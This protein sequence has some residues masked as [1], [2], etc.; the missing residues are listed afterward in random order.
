[1]QLI[2]QTKPSS[3]LFIIIFAILGT[4][5][6]AQDCDYR[7]PLDGKTILSGSYGEPRTKH[8]HA[9]IDY[10]Q[11]RGIPYDTIRA[12]ADGYISRINV[13][14]DGYGNALYIDHPCGQTSVYAH[15]YHF[16]PAI[17]S[18]IEEVQYR[19][20][21]NAIIHYPEAGRLGVSK[22]D[23]IGIMGSTGR[24]SGP[25][26]HF[27]IRDTKTEVSINPA[28]YNFKPK[29]NIPPV[30][31]GIILYNLSPDGQE[32]S[33]T[34]H[35][36]VKTVQGYVTQ[37]A[38]ITTGA[39][40]VGVG[41]HTYDT[42]NG[43]SNHNGIYSLNLMVDQEGQYRF[44][45]DS[46]SFETSQF[47]H[48]HMDY[49]A[50]K[51]K[52]Y[53]TKCFKNPG[54]PLSIYETRGEAGYL[55][56]YEYRAR[57]VQVT[58]GDIEG[59]IAAVSFQLMRSDAVPIASHSM[60]RRRAVRLDHMDSLMIDGHHT[61]LMLPDGLV[62]APFF[63][64]LD[65]DDQ[66]EVDLR[67]EEEIPMFRYIKVSKSLKPAHPRDQYCFT[68]VND[69]GKTTR[70]ATKWENDSTLVSFLPSFE[71]YQLE[72]DTVPPTIQIL[73]MPGMGKRL[74]FRLS[75]NYEPAYRQDDLR[76]EVLLDGKWILCQHDIKSH[77]IWFDMTS[78][79]QKMHDVIISA[80][81]GSN[82]KVRVER[83]FR[84]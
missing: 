1:L 74:K 63:L 32:I 48:S 8:F 5:V 27:E 12:V 9:G 80:K 49:E 76:Y 70:Y 41:I 67:Q 31:R 73:S 55:S 56:L 39:M 21:K 2:S 58:V 68:S 47:I 54:N 11:Q 60:S 84:Y 71:K 52:K 64:D 18:Y 81:D 14:P 40:T 24:S 44:K 57:D 83:S 3:L 25:H 19:A 6:S 53:F 35:K 38:I 51:N 13:R 30:I 50:K 15:L 22:G 43:A 17:K 10:K 61:D 42:M 20:K 26:L 72:R 46:L 16:A 36:A 79:D 7:S 4:I 34:Y 77:M 29:D 62:A 28:L 66:S 65:T 59:N 23:Y 37:P 82:N 33:K 69:K 45:L 75:D 78:S